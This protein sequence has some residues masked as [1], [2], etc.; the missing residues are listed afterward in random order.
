[1]E[2]KI[3]VT[4]GTQMVNSLILKPLTNKQKKCSW[5][6]ENKQRIGIKSS[7]K[8]TYAWLLN[9]WKHSQ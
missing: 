8:R 1:M 2:K 6:N 7:H 4:C 3:F 9:I 5:E